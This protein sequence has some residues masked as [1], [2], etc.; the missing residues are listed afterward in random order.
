[1]FCEAWRAVIMITKTSQMLIN[2]DN[3]F[4]CF[5]NKDIAIGYK[6]KHLKVKEITTHTTYDNG[7]R[8][9][10]SSFSFAVT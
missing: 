4:L 2:N 9:I 6:N 8:M 10:N 3:F 5:F 7:N 1:M